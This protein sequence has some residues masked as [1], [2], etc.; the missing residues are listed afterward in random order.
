MKNYVDA[1][2][3]LEEKAS[4]AE[5]K[6]SEYRQRAEDSRWDQC[7]IAHEAV[8]DGGFTQTG[9]ASEVR[10]PK[11]TIR[12]QCRV[13][14]QYGEVSLASRPTYGEA[15]AQVL[16]TTQSAETDRKQVSNAR[17]VLRDPDLAR[18][19][20]ADPK[21]RAV[22]HEAIQEIHR[23]QPAPRAAA[24]S[25]D[26]AFLRCVDDMARVEQSLIR[27]TENLNDGRKNGFLTPSVLREFVEKLR[28]YADAVED[29]AASR[30]LT[31]EALAEWIGA[32]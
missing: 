13:W 24:P 23:A 4:T 30:G 5:S 25:R 29:I 31:D 15:V 26:D 10:R 16:G 1:Y 27:L 21:V 28:L 2:L 32:E 12:R 14:E 6:V 9:F 17:A 11:E 18:E 20:L 7:R 19:L 3:R 22:A 8:S